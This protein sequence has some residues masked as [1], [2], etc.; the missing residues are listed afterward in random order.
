MLANKSVHL[1]KILPSSHGAYIFYGTKMITV[2]LNLYFYI[3]K[4]QVCKC[5]F[6]LIEFV[7][8]LTILM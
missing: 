4:E 8:H 7:L 3:E 2:V 1:T 5:F 6:L